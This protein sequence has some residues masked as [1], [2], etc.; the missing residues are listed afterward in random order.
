MECGHEV[1]TGSSPWDKIGSAND[2]SSLPFMEIRYRML[3]KA[4]DEVRMKRV[5]L[6]EEKRRGHVNDSE[7]A[8]SLLKIIVETN[9]LTKERESI[10]YRLK[11]HRS[12]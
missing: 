7:Y 10:A 4:M 8:A 11:S 6:E 9:S 12:S 3:G 2:A 1:T 5:R